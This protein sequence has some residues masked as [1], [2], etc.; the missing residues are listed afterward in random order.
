MVSPSHYKSLSFLSKFFSVKD[1]DKNIWETGYDL[2]WAG[3]KFEKL[4]SIT[5]LNFGFSK[6]INFILFE[7]VL[8]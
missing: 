2:C 7:Q 5:F 1:E 6:T 8:N 3:L 4:I